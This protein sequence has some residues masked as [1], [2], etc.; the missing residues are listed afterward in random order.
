MK[1]PLNIA[2][3]WHMHQPL[4]KEP[5]TGE[6]VL[7]WV[8]YHGTKDYLGMADML[9]EFPSI[10]QVFNLVPSLVEQLNDYAAGTA[11]DRYM[12]VT[13]KKAP[14]LTKGD[15]AFLLE[16]F[17]HANW[18]TMIK[19]V[20][21]YWELLKKRGFSAREEDIEAAIRY[22]TD[23]DFLDLQVLF[24]LAWID[25]DI[26][27]SDASLGALIKKGRDYTE[28][29]K[30]ILVSRQ[31]EIIKMI[32]PMYSALKDRGIIELT[33]SPY[34]HP[35]LPLLCDS[36]SAT[37]AMPDAVLPSERFTHPE[38]A[39]G[40]IERAVALHEK[41]F[42]VRPSG[43]WPSEGSVSMDM[44]RLVKTCGMNWVATDEEILAASTGKPVWRDADGNCK[45]SAIYRPYEVAT[46]AGPV[47]VLFRDKVLSDLIGFDYPRWDPEKAAG[48]FIKRLQWVYDMVAEPQSHIVN[49]I[50]DGENAWEY[51]RNNGRDF[52]RALYSRLSESETLRCVTASEF[53]SA[54]PEREPLKRIASGSWINRNFKIWIGHPEDNTAWDYISAARKA[55]VSHQESAGTGPEPDEV[56]GAWTE[57]YAAEG[58]DWFWWYGDEHSSM[59]EGD[60]DNLFRLHLKKIYSLLGAEAPAI[61]DV[62]II[63]EE[64]G[65]VPPK[66]PRGFIQPAIDGEITNYYEWLYAGVLERAY[67]SG[68]MHREGEPHGLIHAVAYG[69]SL[70]T[71]FF[72]FDYMKDIVPYRGKWSFTLNFLHPA[73]MR[74]R[75][76]VE[77][78]DAKGTVWEKPSDEKEWVEK[79]GLN[80]LASGDVVETGIPFSELVARVGDELRLFIDIEGGELGFE[81]WPARGFL[82]IEVPTEDFES[83]NWTV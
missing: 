76:T 10:H 11:K 83:L 48:D 55:I 6:Y 18:E 52:L 17:F 33:T 25:P 7:P 40:Q 8:L 26:A 66:V 65:Y 38:D 23:A 54:H 72:R 46:P 39:L 47:A 37:E 34:Y 82:L 73:R 61:L 21:R 77:G 3:L 80:L 43:M 14:A 32:I 67:L 29:D 45:I 58:S 24:N 74:V 49:I 28:G 59:C 9:N 78:R 19:P 42:G 16:R 63:S 79:G 5:F 71:L 30:K 2:F 41:T 60:F 64:R 75:V 56:K 51:Y 12:D 22:F 69:F 1:K 50:L 35:I 31:I 44:M 57:L 53:L 27:A 70:S 15:R 4:Y 68:A 81:R 62:P 20:G 13:L 36:L